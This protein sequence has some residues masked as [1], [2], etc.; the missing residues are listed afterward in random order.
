MAAPAACRLGLVGVLVAGCGA[1][2]Q[3]VDQRSPA[4]LLPAGD[5]VAVTV[6]STGTSPGQPC[7]GTFARHPLGVSTEVDGP[8]RMFDSNG[9]GVAIGDL[10]G[11]GDLDLVF[12]NLDGPDSILWNEGGL[13]FSRTTLNDRSSR[14]VATVDV[15]GDGRLEIVFTHRAGTVSIWRSSADAPRSFDRATVD[16]IYRRA[17]AMNWLDLDGNGWLDV[18]TGS[19]D[20]ESFLELRDTFLQSDGDGIWAYRQDNGRFTGERLATKSDALSIAFPDLDGDGRRD[21]LVGNDFLTPDAAWRSSDSGLVPI[22]RPLATTT[23]DT[24]SLA[25]ADVDNDGALELF[26]TDMKPYGTD[27]HTLAAWLPVFD[28]M[29]K[30]KPPSDPQ[31]IA[32]VLQVR[33]GAGVY[34]DRATDRG[35]AASGWSWSSKFG[36]LDSDGSLDLYV[37]NGMI[38]GQS[39]AHL[40]GN[41]LVETNRL[42]RNLGGGV[43]GPADEWGLGATE[44][45]RGMS[46]ADLDGDG[47][48]DIV[49]NNLGTEAVLFEN[50][51]CGGTSVQVD[52]RWDGSHNTRAIGARLALVTSAGTLRRD[53]TALSGYLSGDAPRQHFGVPRGASIDRLV[54]GWPDGR[55]SSVADVAPGAM[56]TVTRTDR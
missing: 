29:P 15:D 13:E 32:N 54:V 5:P 18:V 24:M 47:D 53:V 1:A 51:L 31:Q 20:A 38:D 11:D 6:G 45:G 55:V 44:S 43:F 52:L 27:V 46:M 14:A 33:D 25:E 30:Q 34:R 8:I 35:L 16:G 23:E 41:E 42:F 56:L 28:K 19:Y 49:V 4:E 9:A 50:R 48:L 21:L 10:D 39:L 12:A 26:A 40:P 17:Y 3:A 37:V 7:N 22:D 2:F 36:D